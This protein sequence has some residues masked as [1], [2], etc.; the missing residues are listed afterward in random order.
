LR[1]GHEVD[2]HPSAY[3]CPSC[4]PGTETDDPGILEVVFRPDLAA[5]GLVADLAGSRRGVFRFRSLLPVDDDGSGLPVGDTPL[6]P[7][8]RLAERLGLGALLLKDETRNP[9][10]CL[11]DRATAVAVQLAGAAGTTDLYCASAG[12][13]A[14]SLAGFAAHRGLPCHVFVPR[15]ASQER[16]SWLRYF[17]ADIHVSAGDY[18]VAFQE[19]EAMGQ[20][21]GWYSRNCAFNPFLVEGKKTAAFEIAEA[22]SWRAPDVVVAP[23]GDGCTLSALG[24]GF[25]ELQTCGLVAEVPELLGVQAEAMQ[26]MVRRFRG[27]P[28]S[29]TGKTDAASIN[30][31]QP[32]NARRLLKEMGHAGGSM[33]AVTDD[34]IGRAQVALAREA[35][36]VVEFS[37]A[38]GLAGLASMARAGDHRHRTAVVLLTGGRVDAG[39]AH[40]FR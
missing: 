18:D 16:L 21:Q 4:G 1:C 2:F 31:R 23:V 13:A 30:V 25:R 28:G 19:A 20:A 11:K 27:G 7:A 14:I 35:G 5:E 39:S 36:I 26:P 32:R 8:P 3:L 15:Y 40:G 10:R 33:T 12:N 17:G 22:L 6:V 37:A 24:K 9:T 29:D 38:A 34:E